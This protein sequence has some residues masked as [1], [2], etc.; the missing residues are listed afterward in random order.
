MSVWR[1]E[2]KKNPLTLRMSVSTSLS[3]RCRMVRVS[4]RFIDI[5]SSDCEPSA[6]ALLHRSSELL[7][8]GAKFLSRKPLPLT[9]LCFCRL[10]CW[11]LLLSEMS[12][13]LFFL[14]SI[15]KYITEY[16]NFNQ[17]F[18]PRKNWVLGWVLYPKPKPKTQKFVYP[19]PKP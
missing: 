14:N 12:N 9:F 10:G 13:C 2:L 8:L 5:I 19:N 17:T 3:C 15:N 7:E 4:L 18:V 1:S 11:L 6:F 16:F